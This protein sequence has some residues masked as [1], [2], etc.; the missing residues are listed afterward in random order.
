MTEHTAFIADESGEI[1]KATVADP[2]IAW[3]GGVAK[4]SETIAFAEKRLADELRQNEL[5][6]DNAHD[7]QYWRAY[8][9]GA[10][11][12]AKEDER[13]EALE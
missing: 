2:N 1:R 11:A 3:H 9:D 5:G 6:L 10:K 7:I 8:L 4:T 13:E 12:Q